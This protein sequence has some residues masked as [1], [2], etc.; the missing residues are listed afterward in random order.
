MFTQGEEMP[1]NT[2]GVRTA[3]PSPFSPRGGRGRALLH[4]SS[5]AAG[6]ILYDLSDLCHVHYRTT[7]GGR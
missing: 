6:C 2:G 1:P 4:A 3:Q 5:A 7:D